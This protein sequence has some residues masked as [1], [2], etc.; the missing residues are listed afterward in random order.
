MDFLAV[1]IAAAAGFAFGAVWYGVLSKPWMEAVGLKL[2][3]DGKPEG[4]SKTPF[5]LAGIA[6]ILVAGMMR[7]TFSL[8]GIDT[9][10]KGLL[11]GLGVGLFFIS[12]WIMINNGYAGRPFRLTLIDSGYATFGC[13][14]IGLVLMLF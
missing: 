4:S 2:G 12:P 3:A 10:G 5:I 14:I 9:M 7:H 11:S 6:M 1:I 13:A 8:S